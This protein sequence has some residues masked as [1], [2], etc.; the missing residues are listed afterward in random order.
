ML[1]C[2]YADAIVGIIP[3]PITLNQR[4]KSSSYHKNKHSSIQIFTKNSFDFVPKMRSPI[5]KSHF[6]HKISKCEIHIGL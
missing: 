6:K 5:P 1:R 4:S 3:Q 2:I